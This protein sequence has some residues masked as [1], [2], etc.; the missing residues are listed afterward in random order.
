MTQEVIDSLYSEN[1]LKPELTVE[2]II[3]MKGLIELALNW[4]EEYERKNLLL[5]GKP[6]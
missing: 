3:D 1:V 5:L 2:I 4:N 6:D